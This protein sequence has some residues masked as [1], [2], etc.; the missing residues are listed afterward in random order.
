MTFS[1]DQQLEEERTV[2]T[3]TYSIENQD[4]IDE[5][6]RTWHVAQSFLTTQLNV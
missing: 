4:M 3:P 2:K 6:E 5:S 1:Y